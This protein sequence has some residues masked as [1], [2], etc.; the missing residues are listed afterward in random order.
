[1]STDS[2]GCRSYVARLAPDCK[3]SCGATFLKNVIIYQLIIH[4][5]CK[6]IF[7][8]TNI[9]NMWRLICILACV[10]VR[11]MCYTTWNFFFFSRQLGHLFFFFYVFLL[12][13][14]EGFFI[15]MVKICTVHGL[16]RDWL[17][18]VFVYLC[19]KNQLLAWSLIWVYILFRCIVKR[20]VLNS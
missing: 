11:K 20:F 17:I 6:R 8:L 15:V 19:K 1:M 14:I 13:F 9:L 7:F 18:F 3:M 4:D 2:S 5:F 10:D 12:L 16:A